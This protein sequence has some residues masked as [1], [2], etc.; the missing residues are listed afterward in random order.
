MQRSSVQRRFAQVDVF[1]AEPFLGNP[2]AVV[3]DG[4]GVA[5][6]DM[7]AFARWTNLSETT[8]LLPPTTPEADYR[9]RIFTPGREL[10]FAGHPTL[11]SAHAWLAAG[12]VPRDAGVLVQ[13]CA[14][15]LVRLRV[16]DGAIAFAAPPRQ[17][18]G[19]VDEPT[20]ARGAAALGLAREEIL[21]HEWADNGP[22]WL[23]L[24]LES[25]E[26][27]LAIRPDSARLGGL[28]VGVVGPH[29]AGAECAFE[30]RAFIPDAGVPEDPVTGSLNAGIAQWLIGAGL[31]PERYVAAQG[32]AM[33]RAG[34][35]LVERVG[36]D[37]WIGGATATLIEG[38]VR[39]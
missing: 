4:D 33:G 5:D 7:A 11:G 23:A 30:V 3:V 10:P 34:R 24:R 6:A 39:L 22:G 15:G 32:T 28:A 37:V 13:E 25:A 1:G 35:V 20:L 27:V 31:A 21:G 8:F 12:G 17:R 18:T 2:V 19:P 16:S 38:T 9:L 29:P 26:R 36:D 14:A